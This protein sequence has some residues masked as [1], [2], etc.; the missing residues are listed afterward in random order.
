MRK[1]IATAAAVL[2]AMAIGSSGIALASNGADDPAP[3]HHGE[4]GHHGKH[5]RQEHHHRR[6]H[7]HGNED[8]HRGGDDDGPNH[9]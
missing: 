3:H 2:A 9:G 1:R 8:R 4:P 7:R 5:H 6:H